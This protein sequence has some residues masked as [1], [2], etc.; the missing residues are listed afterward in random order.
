MP[1]PKHPPKQ[2]PE[3]VNTYREID[4]NAPIEIVFQVI[5]DFES[6]SEIESPIQSVTITSK[7]RKGKGV[8]S[9]WTAISSQTGEVFEW[10]EE[11]IYYDPPYQ[12]AFR[13]TSG[14]EPFEGV[15]TLSE[16]PDGTTHLLLSETHFFPLDV[17]AF[18]PVIEGLVS[19]VKKAAEKRANR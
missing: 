12:Y 17:D 19:N 8:T 18:A 2:N 9:H 4:I 7:H 3:D 5:T 13:V 10:D 15:H 16:N 1:Y 11:V 14:N 6:F